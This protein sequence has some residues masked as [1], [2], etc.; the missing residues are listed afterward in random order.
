M[1]PQSHRSPFLFVFPTMPHSCSDFVT[2]SAITSDSFCLT[3]ADSDNDPNSQAS[4]IDKPQLKVEPKHRSKPDPTIFSFAWSTSGD[5]SD[6]TTNSDSNHSTRSHSADK[7]SSSMPSSG[8]SYV[9][10]EVRAARASKK[11]E[12]EDADKEPPTLPNAKFVS[13][14]THREVFSDYINKKHLLSHHHSGD[15]PTS[16]VNVDAGDSASVQPPKIEELTAKPY[17]N[18]SHIV[19]AN[20][21]KK[22]IIHNCPMLWVTQ[23]L[24]GDDRLPVP[25]KDTLLIDD[26][27]LWRP[28]PI[29]ETGDDNFVSLPSLGSEP[30]AMKWFQ[31]LADKLGRLHGL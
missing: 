12:A 15:S 5:D 23:Y 16:G 29:Q 17:S 1:L 20:T 25:F 6:T 10:P 8:D 4:V 21:N 11:G 26:K 13:S 27:D 18:I 30:E 22:K 31:N 9:P 14:L 19:L 3:T 24:L 2:F 7:N 28:R